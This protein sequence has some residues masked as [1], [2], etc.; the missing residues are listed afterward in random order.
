MECGLWIDEIMFKSIS[1]IKIHIFN[2]EQIT[3]A[4]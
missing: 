3:P 2:N 1:A 4:L